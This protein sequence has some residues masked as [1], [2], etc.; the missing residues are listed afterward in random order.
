MIHILEVPDEFR[1]PFPFPYPGHQRGPLAEE[2]VHRFLLEHAAQERL[3][4]SC[5]SRFRSPS[6]SDSAAAAADWVYVPVYWTSY[7]VLRPRIRGLR[8]LFGHPWDQRLRKFLRGALQP[9]VR[10]CTLSM[11]DNGLRQRG[12]FIPPVPILEFSC[13]GCGDIPLPLLCDP[14]PALNLPRDI[15][16]SFLGL[17][18]DSPEPY[19]CR[20]AMVAALAGKAEYRVEH[21]PNDWGSTDPNRLQKKTRMFVEALSRSVFALCPRGY[22][23]T[24]FRMYEALQ[25]GCIP[26]YIYDE[27]WLPYTDVLDWS[28]FAVLVPLAEASG[29]HEILSAHTAADIRRK[30]EAIRDLYPQYFTFPAM[31]RQL[32]RYLSA[33]SLTT[34]AIPPMKSMQ[35]GAQPD[36]IAETVRRLV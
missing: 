23:K 33:P 36:G 13:G 6:E 16:A 31:A 22:G 9:G 17:I 28:E 12:R 27:P 25:L 35:K 29:L 1:Q 8:R 20:E 4:R 26:V 32:L 30:Q 15:R 19:P 7:S 3:D 34:A 21:V 10:Y 2:F 11:H 5:G 18:K 14:H 24:S